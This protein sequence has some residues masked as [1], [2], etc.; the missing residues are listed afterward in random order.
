MNEIYIRK[1]V[2]KYSKSG[3]YLIVPESVRGGGSHILD[4]DENFEL[5]NSR[6]LKGYPRDSS[7][8]YTKYQADLTKKVEGDY[9]HYKILRIVDNKDLELQHWSP[10]KKINQ[11]NILESTHITTEEKF[12]AGEEKGNMSIISMYL[13][14]LSIFLFA[15]YKTFDEGSVWGL[16]LSLLISFFMIRAI[17]KEGIHF[18]KKP[19]KE[20]I[21]ELL[22]HKRD[23]IEGKVKK[24][25]EQMNTLEKNL[26]KFSYWQSLDPQSFE[27][28]LKIYLKK[29][30][31]RLNVSQYSGDGGVDLEG[32][33][34]SDNP[35]IIQAKKYSKA[36]GVAVVREMLGI[37][38]SKENTPRTII[39]ALNGFTNGA[40][41]FAKENNIELKSIR[42]DLLEI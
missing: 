11:L 16:G 37:K 15:S 32:K 5:K 23:L 7:L 29:K 27:V 21:E 24:N 2:L 14:I 41:V 19:K 13:I 9:V 4:L 30:N 38:R 8:S 1:K 25:A 12:W 40:I 35:V 26:E 31:F 17:F 34:D 28:G 10:N 39:Y 22:K 42:K 18:S 20:K 36:V 33:D 6:S 3:K